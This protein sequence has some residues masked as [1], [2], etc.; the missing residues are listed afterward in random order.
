VLVLDGRGVRSLGRARDLL[1]FRAA[2]IEFL[3]E[4]LL[5]LL[6]EIV[7][8]LVFE[9]TTE[10][11]WE[12]LRAAVGKSRRRPGV[13]A[14]VGLVVMG[15]VAGVLSVLAFGCRLTPAG[16]VSGIERTRRF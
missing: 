16:G 7:M 1:T 9:I 10:L 2:R 3:L 5:Q 15:G 12:S 11:G 13:L 14:G 8:R 6:F 4:L